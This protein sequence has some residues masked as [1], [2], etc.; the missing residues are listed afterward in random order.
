LLSHV[1]RIFL[2]TDAQNLSSLP[3][4]AERLQR[5]FDGGQSI[6]PLPWHLEHRLLRSVS[7]SEDKIPVRLK[8]ILKL[9]HRP[10]RVVIA[11]E[12]AAAAA[13]KGNG[14][15]AF[16]IAYIPAGQKDTYNTL[17][18]AKFPA[19]WVPRSVVAV[20]NGIAYEIGDVAIRMGEVRAAGSSAQGV[21]AVLVSI[22]V[23]SLEYGPDGPTKEEEET[24]KSI[25]RSV[26]KRI[27]DDKQLEAAKEAWGFGTDTSQ[28]KAWC[29]TLKSR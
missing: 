22:E 25:I 6:S 18:A 26:W 2:L 4:L 5:A 8:H 21:R 11:I 17:L 13:A 19:L 29:E 9:G 16:D 10:S 27:A 15:G 14:G 12:D 28:V 20:A 1:R 7:A 23:T 3:K 24:A